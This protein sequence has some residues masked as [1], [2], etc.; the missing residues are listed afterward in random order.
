[1]LGRAYTCLI[2]SV[3]SVDRLSRS[4]SLV[5]W[6]FFFLTSVGKLGSMESSLWA[7]PVSDMRGALLALYAVTIMPVFI[8]VYIHINVFL[9]Y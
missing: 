3:V 5:I 1:M 7:V 6:W 9:S 4:A 2:F 8:A